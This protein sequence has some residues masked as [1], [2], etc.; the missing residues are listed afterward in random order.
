MKSKIHLSLMVLKRKD[1]SAC[2]VNLEKADCKVSASVDVR[3]VTCQRCK[4]T[5]AFKEET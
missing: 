1:R 5:K 3:E 2:G 4:R